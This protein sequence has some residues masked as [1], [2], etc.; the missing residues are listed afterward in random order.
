MT[1]ALL[2]L[3]LCIVGALL[4]LSLNGSAR[5]IATALFMIS[6]WSAP[7]IQYSP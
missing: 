3:A 6:A 2:S 1:I 4:A 7:K 5:V